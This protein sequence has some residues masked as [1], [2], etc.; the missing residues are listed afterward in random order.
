M[1]G[2]TLA[3][4]LVD[5]DP[6][7]DTATR[8]TTIVAWRT[9]FV[10]QLGPD[11]LPVALVT[12]DPDAQRAHDE[13]LLA[14]LWL[15][16]RAVAPVNEGPAFLLTAD[17]VRSDY[18]SLG[19]AVAIWIASDVP[20]LGAPEFRDDSAPVVGAFVSASTY[21]DGPTLLADRALTSDL[22]TLR[23]LEA[24]GRLIT[25]NQPGVRAVFTQPLPA[26]ETRPLSLVWQRDEA[27]T[28]TRLADFLGPADPRAASLFVTA[29]EHGD[30]AAMAE[31]VTRSARTGDLES[32]KRWAERLVATGAL[33]PLRWAAEQ[34][35]DA[36]LQT[37]LLEAMAQTGDTAAMVQLATRGAVAWGDRLAADR[38]WDAL[39]TAADAVVEEALALRWIERA[40]T[41]GY[42]DAMIRAMVR[43]PDRAQYWEERIIAT[44]DPQ[45]A[46]A[47]AS[48]AGNNDRRLRLLEAAARAGNRDA[49]QQLSASPDVTATTSSYWRDQL[50]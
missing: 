48:Q 27:A 40:A 29:A 4:V 19:E 44:S 23:G 11:R 33:P 8:E 21:L 5:E 35:G 28:G 45:V 9:A 47:A 6:G 43:L 2:P 13:L 32:A 31:L 20:L 10:G 41:G 38:K 49:M 18:T 1:T 25:P 14:S 17:G 46:L 3:V 22:A 39:L 36:D 34:V 26:D 7:V 15:D 50:G 16:Q 37:F 24:R 30:A 42:P 12:L